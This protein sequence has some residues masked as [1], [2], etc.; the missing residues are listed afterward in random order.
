MGKYLAQAYAE[1]FCFNPL[2]TDYITVG[3][4]LSACCLTLS[5][6]SNIAGIDTMKD[7]TLCIGARENWCTTCVMLLLITSAWH[8]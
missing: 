7:Y 2:A 6:I 3:R 5:L 4:Q 1:Q 8:R